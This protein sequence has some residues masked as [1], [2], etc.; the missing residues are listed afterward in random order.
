ML[1]K[2]ILGKIPKSNNGLLMINQEL[3]IH[4]KISYN[5]LEDKFWILSEG[6]SLI[7]MK[8]GEDYYE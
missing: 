5:Y 3:L 1:K 8:Q 4:Y 7:N 6:L 2:H